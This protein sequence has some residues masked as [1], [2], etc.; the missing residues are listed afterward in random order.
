MLGAIP[1]LHQYASMALC[2]V[3][4]QRQLYI[5]ICLKLCFLT[6]REERRLKVFEKML[7]R[8]IFGSKRQ[9]VAGGWR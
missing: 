1:L 3:E 6:V 8:G 5:F 9:K 2:P 7:Q 4:A